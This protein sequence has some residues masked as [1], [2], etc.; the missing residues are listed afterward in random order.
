MVV[1]LGQVRARDEQE[2]AHM[3]AGG[4]LPR[5]GEA[6]GSV[7]R[8]EAVSGRGPRSEQLRYPHWDRSSRAL[9]SRDSSPRARVAARTEVALGPDEPGPARLGVALRETHLHETRG[10]IVA[11]R[12]GRVHVRLHELLRHGHG[13]SVWLRR[14]QRTSRPPREMRASPQSAARSAPRRRCPPSRA[15]RAAARAPPPP[16]PRPRRGPWPG[17][18]RRWR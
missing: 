10:R 15:T 8:G 12:S 4:N 17:R 1:A 6:P 7:Q 11:R 16:S 5:A 9:P 13:T 18:T 2:I 3:A 14:P